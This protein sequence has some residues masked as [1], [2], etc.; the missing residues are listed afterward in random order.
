MAFLKAHGFLWSGMAWLAVCAGCYDLAYDPS[1]Q[2]VPPELTVVQPEQGGTYDVEVV[3]KA[4]AIDAEDGDISANVV[5]TEGAQI[6]G[7]GSEVPRTFEVGAHTIKAAV[8]DADG[9]V[10]EVTVTFQVAIVE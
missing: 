3:L 6:L 7:R 1:S 8:S 2:N 9:G 10:A 4:A 5:W